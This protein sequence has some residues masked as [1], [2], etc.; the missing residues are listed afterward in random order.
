MN[1]AYS[2]FLPAVIGEANV[3]KFL[4]LRLQTGDDQ[5]PGKLN[6]RSAFADFD[7]YAETDGENEFDPELEFIGME[8][9]ARAEKAGSHFRPNSKETLFDL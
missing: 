3:N 9:N 1:H 7:D 8:G 4:Q 5:L 2:E 6:A